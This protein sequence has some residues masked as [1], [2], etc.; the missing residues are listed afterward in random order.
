MTISYRKRSF[1]IASGCRGGL[2]SDSCRGRTSIPASGCAWS[3]TSNPCRG[4]IMPLVS[5]QRER[6]RKRQGRRTQRGGQEYAAPDR[7][8]DRYIAEMVARA[9][10][11]TENGI[12]NAI[13]GALSLSGVQEVH[14][15]CDGGS[16]SETARMIPRMNTLSVPIHTVSIDGGAETEMKQIASQSN[17]RHRSIS[18]GSRG[19]RGGMPFGWGTHPGLR[20]HPMHPG[21][22]GWPGMH[23]MH[24]GM[25]GWP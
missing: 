14:L 12:T 4:H 3:L 16:I 7:D 22:P 15:M 11:S 1:T 5:A 6:R 9:T 8:A 10:G 20:G 24:P 21:M 17:G 2:L 18:C 23:P 13:Q 25:P 19:G